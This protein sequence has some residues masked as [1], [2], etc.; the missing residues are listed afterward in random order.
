MVRKK[1]EEEKQQLRG[2]TAKVKERAEKLK[3]EC[4]VQS[5]KIDEL[6]VDMQ[7]LK[8]AK[9]KTEI[10]LNERIEER[11]KYIK[12]IEQ[13]YTQQISQRESEWKDKLDKKEN[14]LEYKEIEIS[15]LKDDIL[16]LKDEI[17]EIKKDKKWFKDYTIDQDKKIFKYFSEHK[18]SDLKNHYDTYLNNSDKAEERM[19]RFG[20]KGV[21]TK[22]TD[23][24]EIDE[25]REKNSKKES[26]ENDTKKIPTKRIEI[27]EQNNRWNQPDNDDLE[28][29]IPQPINRR[30]E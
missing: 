24:K 27:R 21:F 22:S 12:E 23:K 11:N 28:G 4:D 1:F 25:N 13:E 2:E 6:T 5:S 18:E 19:E 26:M 20:E 29:S 10:K 7:R 8:D 30:N 3:T 15:G 14:N 16:D 9:S 17:S